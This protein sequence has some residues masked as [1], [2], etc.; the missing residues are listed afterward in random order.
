MNDR[1]RVYTKVLQTLKKLMP[2]Q[3]QGHVVTLAMMMTGIVIGKKAQLSPMSTEV[4]YPA[5]DKS[6]ERRMRRWVANERIDAPIYFMP[7]AESLLATLSGHTLVLAM[8][9]S[10]VG[11]GCMV[12]MVG[13]I[14]RKRAIPIAWVVYKGKKGHAP[15]ETHIEVLQ[16]VLPLI[17]DSSDVVLLGD[18]EYDTTEMLAWVEEKTDWAFVVR[19][20][21]NTLI[22][23]EDDW[24][25]LSELDVTQ[26]NIIALFGVAFTQ[27]S[28]YGPVQAIAW[29]G[30]DND[31]P[32]YLVTNLT[33]AEEACY[34]YG[35]RYRI[36]TLFSDKKS[37]GFNIHKSHLS[38]PE[39][40][41]NLLMATSLAYMWI[42]YLGVEV[43]R[44]GNRHLIDR[45]DRR[46]KS[47]FRL[48]LDWLKHLLKHSKPIPIQFYLPLPLL[49]DESVR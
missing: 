43:I 1:R 27:K 47:L 20:A 17:P 29:W 9:G 14:Y 49:F 8:D 38:A 12:L 11:R 33:L 3:K 22:R 41:S 35:K 32:L 4:P 28:A 5:K 46:D 31:D 48:G 2:T 18:G 36:E 37:R 42:I 30:R 34:F 25:S 24:L 26:G 15:A 39:R 21:S 13:V 23:S 6:I 7:F 19:T 45:T 10:T 44:Q 40:I 16:K